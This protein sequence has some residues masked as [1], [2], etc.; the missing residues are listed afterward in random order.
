M[1][2][3]TSMEFVFL[4]IKLSFMHHLDAERQKEIENSESARFV[5]GNWIFGPSEISNLCTIVMFLFS[6]FLFQLFIIDV[7]S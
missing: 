5:Y 4:E 3:L 6:S 1:D 7:K 2:A